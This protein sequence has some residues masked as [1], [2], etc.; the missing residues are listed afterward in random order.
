MNK[1]IEPL[2][3]QPKGTVQLTATTSFDSL[4]KTCFYEYRL[5]IYRQVN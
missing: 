4:K 3:K 2:R 5:L 1:N